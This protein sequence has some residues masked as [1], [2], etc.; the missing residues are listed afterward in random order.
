MFLQPDRAAVAQLID[1]LRLRREEIAEDAMARIRSEVPSYRDVDDGYAADL[2]EGLDAH[3]ER[4]LDAVGA[5]RVPL[6]EELAFT[7]PYIARRVR[8]TP[9]EDFQQAFRIY[10]ATFWDTLVDAAEACCAAGVVT[11]AASVVLR[12]SHL[13]AAESAERYFEFQRLLRAHGEQVRRDLF[14]DLLAGRR[15][16]AGPKLNAAREAGLEPPRPYV[17]TV[18]TPVRALDEEQLLHSAVLALA[19]GPGGL[20]PLT[21][22]RQDEVA[23]VTPIGADARSAIAVVRTAQATL[24]ADGIVLAIGVSTVRPDLSEVGDAYGE[25]SAAA[26]RIAATG[27]VAALPELTVFDC[28]LDYGV[29]AAR[30]RIPPAIARFVAADRGDGGMLTRTLREYVAADLNVK[31]AAARLHVHPNTAR[32]RLAKI[33]EHTGCDLR[34]LADVLDLVI[35]SRTAA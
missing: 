26:R 3:F 27:G 23:T 20:R 21:I 33:E 7:H 29:E 14:E 28:L 24:A 16:S 13:M 10:I 6:R 1:A 22:V 32:Y 4:I 2:R 30:R 25:A 12:Y 15:P 9:F 5:N 18:A 35:A 34:R 17:V 31:L 19:R 8:R 11:A